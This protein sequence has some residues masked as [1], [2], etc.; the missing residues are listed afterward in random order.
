VVW[1]HPGAQAIKLSD[2]E[3][4]TLRYRLIIHDGIGSS[5]IAELFRLFGD[6]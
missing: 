2:A 1:P 6:H 3:P 5:E 4:V